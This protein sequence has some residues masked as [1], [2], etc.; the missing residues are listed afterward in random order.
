MCA[1]G[2]SGRLERESSRLRTPWGCARSIRDGI[3][4]RGCTLVGAASL[5]LRLAS[6]VIHSTTRAHVRLL[7]PCFKTGRVGP[8]FYSPL[9]A[10]TAMHLCIPRKVTGH[11]RAVLLDDAALVE[12]PK[13]Q[14]SLTNAPCNRRPVGRGVLLGPPLA[15]LGA[16]NA[17]P[18]QRS[19]R[20][21]RTVSRSQEGMQPSAGSG[22]SFDLRGP[23]RLTP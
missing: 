20:Q 1:L 4:P 13:P 11:D 15:D 22:D 14:N 8:D 3:T 9:W 18:S 10:S 2:S 21:V 5:S 23:T 16:A 6:F 19:S 7:G 12:E 17:F